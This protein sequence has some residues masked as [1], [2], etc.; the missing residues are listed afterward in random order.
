LIV[1][2]SI[3]IGADLVQAGGEPVALV[4]IASAAAWVLMMRD[5][6]ANP[7]AEPQWRGINQLIDTPGW[8]A[9]PEFRSCTTW[10]V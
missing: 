7:Q 3:G 6:R 9:R 8:P 10:R 4:L 2:L 5:L 1:P